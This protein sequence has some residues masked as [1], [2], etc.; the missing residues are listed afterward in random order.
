MSRSMSDSPFP[1]LPSPISPPWS[2]QVGFST[3][4]EWRS[5]SHA[6]PSVPQCQLVFCSISSSYQAFYFTTVEKSWRG[7]FVMKMREIWGKHQSL[8]CWQ[9]QKRYLCL[10]CRT[11]YI[12]IY[13]VQT[14]MIEVTA[15]C[16]KGLG[17][18]HLYPGNTS[19]HCVTWQGDVNID[20]HDREELCGKQYGRIP[21]ANSSIS[22]QQSRS[23]S[24]MCYTAVYEQTER[25]DRPSSYHSW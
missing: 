17:M 7:N 21:M 15:Y 2:P 4:P 9:R 14:A 1:A 20:Q 10:G 3:N 25:S 19:M 23:L 12:Y 11:I 5:H 24:I 18:L 22:G 6:F 16:H 13:G 8:H